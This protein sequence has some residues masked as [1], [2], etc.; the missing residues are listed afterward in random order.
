MEFRLEFTEGPSQ[1]NWNFTDVLTETKP[2]QRNTQKDWQVWSQ[3]SGNHR[4][5]K[6]KA[7]SVEYTEGPTRAKPSQWNTQKDQ[8]GQSQ[9]SGIHRRTN[10]DKA[11]SVKYTEGPTRT[12]PS[13]WNTQKD[14]QGQRQV[15]GIHRS[16]KDLGQLSKTHSWMGQQ[17]QVWKL[18][19]EGL[20][21]G[22]F[23][24]VDWMYYHK[25][26]LVSILWCINT[27][28][29]PFPT[30]KTQQLWKTHFWYQRTFMHAKCLDTWNQ[31]NNKMKKKRRA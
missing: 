15:S 11:K 14:Q 20:T 2:S 31:Q 18:Q 9:V 4:T 19:S 13:Q 26:H 16:T 25:V 7:K 29:N 12:K 27:E 21:R 23:R 6:D 1:W 3:V 30:C 5:N 17:S 10:K 22:L 24:P 8:Q 28:V